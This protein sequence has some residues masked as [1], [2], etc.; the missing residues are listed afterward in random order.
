MTQDLS[1]KNNGQDKPLVTIGITCFNAHD[2]I[3][4]AIDGAFTQDWPNLEVV[5]V[6]DASKDNS[7]QLIEDATKNEPR[8]KLI[9]HTENK[10]FPSALNT[11]LENAS[12]E[13]IAFFDDDDIS[14]QNR[15]TAQVERIMSFESNSNADKVLCYTNRNVVESETMK[16]L[17]SFEAIGRKP[18]EPSGEKVADFI[19][20]SSGEKGYTWGMFGSCTLMMRTDVLRELGG[21]DPHFRRNTEWD[22]AAR[23]AFD[24]AHFIACDAELVT[25]IK[26]RTSDKSG[27]I[28]L[29][30][31]LDLRK[32][33]REY[34]ERKGV[35]TLACIMAYSR[36]Y[37]G[38]GKK[39]KSL[40]F[41]G[42]AAMMA[43]R[44][45]LL[46]ALK[47]RMGGAP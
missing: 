8:V 11:I 17:Y 4:K 26:T 12:G 41:Q 6:D 13:F 42:I 28:P 27:K 7:V 36:F 1:H 22:M 30:Y 38:K 35:Y 14:A 10:G 15:I 20:W 43:P 24:G 39:Y 18:K 21:F 34:L 31:S 33:H 3:L 44:K 25:Q 46:P 23:A 16:P 47:K 9:R 37:G 32:K 2:T 40:F 5:V 29:R 19:L 45:L